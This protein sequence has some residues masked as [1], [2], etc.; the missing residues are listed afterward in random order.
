MTAPHHH[1][2]DHDDAPSTWGEE[3]WDERYRSAPGL[4]SGRP[5]AQLV[6]EA[7]ALEP[8]SALDVGCGEGADAIWLAEHGWMVTASDI[9]SVA[10]ARGA[11]RAAEAAVASRITWVHADL[12]TFDPGAAQYALVSAQFVHFPTEA[13]NAVFPR[14]AA[15]VAPGGS[16]LIV[17]HHPSDLETSVRRPRA[18]EL[19]F[20]PDHV[21]ALLD[22]GEWH[23]AVSEARERTVTDPDGQPVTVRD[24]VLRA[25]RR[26]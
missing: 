23:I 19:L 1:D 20:T 26:V 5:N 18:P 13:R 8:G 24:S 12:V 22:P 7:S 10:L 9:S 3:F 11:A 2:H 21:A 15:A 25:E 14:L 17:G 4:W 16:L 6:A